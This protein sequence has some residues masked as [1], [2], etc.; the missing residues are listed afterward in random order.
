MKVKQE[1]KRVADHF[2]A[3]LQFN[4]LVGSSEPDQVTLIDRELVNWEEHANIVLTSFGSGSE[5]KGIR[6][7]PSLSATDRCSGSCSERS[8]WRFG[9]RNEYD[10]MQALNERLK[11][12]DSERSNAEIQYEMDHVEEHQL[13]YASSQRPFIP[14]LPSLGE[15]S[16]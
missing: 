5:L 10:I 11:A 7:L 16:R 14:T 15:L 13:L 1:T 4:G 2:R 12:V 3:W 8:S 6:K 9:V